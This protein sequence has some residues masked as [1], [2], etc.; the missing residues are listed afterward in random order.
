MATTLET[1]VIEP[2]NEEST[3]SPTVELYLGSLANNWKRAGNRFQLE[4][5]AYNLP[6]LDKLLETIHWRL[7]K[8]SPDEPSLE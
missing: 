8:P 7:V 1:K 6:G 3:D 5:P 4:L 2:I